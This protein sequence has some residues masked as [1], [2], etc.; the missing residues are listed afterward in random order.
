MLHLWVDTDIGGDVDD[1]LALTAILRTEGVRLA[2]ISTG[3]LRP[4]WR[5]QAALEI[6]RREGAAGVTVAVGADTPLCG[7]WNEANIPDTGVTP[8]VPL[9][10]SAEPG[11]EALLRAAREDPELVLLAIGPLTNLA[12]ALRR[13]ADTLRGR[14]LFVMGGR[15]ATAEP[16]WNLLCDPVAAAEVFSSQ[17]EITL[18]P[19]EVTKQTQFSQA[20]VDA[21]RGTETRAFLRGMMDRFTERFGFLPI[22][23][24]PMAFAMLARPELFTFEGIRLSVGQDGGLT[25]GGAPG[26]GRSGEIRV[27]VAADQPA[28]RQWIKAAL[29]KDEEATP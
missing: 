5:A 22:M 19:F 24:D 3:Y 13:D 27:A 20:E 2:G 16:E 14:R 18:V 1:A 12:L 28:F 25:R 8:R 29:M 4:A 11:C 17:M 6:L 21:I 10:V 15:V 23:H 9:P 26:D 7:A